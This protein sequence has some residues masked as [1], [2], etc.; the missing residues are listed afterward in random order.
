MDT[1]LVHA[2][3][4]TSTLNY[5]LLSIL[6]LSSSDTYS[7]AASHLGIS[8]TI[9]TL[10]R[11]LPYHVSKG[12]M[13]IPASITAKH[14]VNQEEVVRKGPS[15]SGLQDAVYEFAIIANDHLIT[16]R[17]M[18]KNESGQIKVPREAMPVF[19]NAVRPSLFR[20]MMCWLT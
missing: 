8:Q 14:R 4:T 19:L 20:L 9:S 3:S 15:A 11:A 2:E 17:E 7:H 16:A 1:L 12:V 5:I 10:L 13:V 18:F 6:G